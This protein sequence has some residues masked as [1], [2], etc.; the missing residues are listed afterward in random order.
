MAIPKTNIVERT[1]WNY[2]GAEWG[3]LNDTLG[4]INLEFLRRA[5]PDEGV[6]KLTEIIL[7]HAHE[8]IGQRTVKEFKSS[9]PWL[10]DEVLVSMKD[11]EDA[12]GT[13]F[14]KVRAE[15][16]SAQIM[17]SREAYIKKK[18]KTENSSR[19]TE[20]VVERNK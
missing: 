7:K 9:H 2:Q 15:E 10:T 13:D 6:M 16:C 11:A 8:A 3:R 12:E 1:V 19:Q 17:K 20:V 18:K 4:E 14:E 5:T